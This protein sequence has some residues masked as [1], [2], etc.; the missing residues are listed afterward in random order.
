[1]KPHSPP[2]GEH[3]ARSSTTTLARSFGPVAQD[4]T[5]LRPGYPISARQA[6]LSAIPPGSLVADLAAGT[7]QLTEGLMQQGYRV[8]AIEPLPE[9]LAEI[10]RRF[11]TALACAGR[12]EAIPLRSG[13][14]AALLVGQAFHWFAPEP[15][16]AEMLRVVRPGGRIGLLWNH[17]RFDRPV[18][19]ALRGVLDRHFGPQRVP[20]DPSNP[21]NPTDEF[22]PLDGRP[23]LENVRRQKFSWSR[24]MSTTDVIELVGTYSYVITAPERVRRSLRSD[25]LDALRPFSLAADTVEL[26]E[27]CE[28]FS[29]T[30]SP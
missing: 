10:H 22:A 18:G 16:L 15:A 17:E 24:L 13:S 23:G 9:M 1:M 7:G 11:P 14:A 30:V 27:D 20:A 8:V 28:V 4:Y 6:V 26:T 12:A 29:A 5:R 25:L 2:T 3:L 21:V 19:A